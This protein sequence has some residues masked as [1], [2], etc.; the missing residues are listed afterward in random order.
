MFLNPENLSR[1]LRE[2]KFKL[3]DFWAA[4]YQNI[5]A[6]FLLE[7]YLFS[8]NGTETNGGWKSRRVKKSHESSFK[9]KR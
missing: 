4:G 6:D 5:P 8:H 9:E 2:G 1:W 3:A 7:T